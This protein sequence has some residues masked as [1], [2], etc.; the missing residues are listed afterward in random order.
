M[1]T[2]RFTKVLFY[3]GPLII[4]MWVIFYFSAQEGSGH[5][6][7]DLRMFIERKNAHVFEYLVLTLLGVRMLKYLGKPLI[8]S[9][10]YATLISLIYAASDEFHQLFVYGRE[11]K[12]S[13]VGIDFIGIVLA[14]FIYLGLMSYQKRK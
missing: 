13:D 11:G 14:F 4:W 1:E 10:V 3:F 9:I 2:K 7:Y 8:K 5:Q 6:Y 12:L